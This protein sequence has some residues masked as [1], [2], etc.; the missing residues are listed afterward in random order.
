MSTTRLVAAFVAMLSLAICLGASIWVFAGTAPEGADYEAW[1][2]QRLA[3]YKTWFQWATLAWFLSGPLW[4]TPEA[5]RKAKP[6][7]EAN[8]AG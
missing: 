3:T 7:E 4:I 8:P 5:F 2:N 6:E 1:Y